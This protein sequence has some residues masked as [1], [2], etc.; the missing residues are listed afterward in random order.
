MTTEVK[1]P[2]PRGKPRTEPGTVAEPGQITQTG[3]ITIPHRPIAVGASGLYVLQPLLNLPGPFAT[4]QGPDSMESGGFLPAIREELRLDVDGRYPQMAASG[5]LR[6]GIAGR[7]NWVAKLNSTAPN[8]FAGPIFHA[9]TTGGP[10]FPYNFV[11]ITVTTSLIPSTQR[12]TA[13]FSTP[14]GSQSIH[15]YRFSSPYFHPVELE[16]DSADGT[17][18]ITTFNTGTH[19]NRPATLPIENLAIE[20]IYQRAGF[21]VTKSGGDGTVPIAGAGSNHRWSNMEMH[22]AMQT[23]WSKFANIAQWSMWV[24]FASLH[25]MGT[26]LGGIM[27]DD[28]GPNHRQGTAI[29]EDAFISVAPPGDPQPAAWVQRMRFW[30]ACHEAGHGFNLAHSWQESLGTPWIPLADEPEGRTFMNYP[31]NVSGGTSAFF[32]NFEYR[33]SDQELLFMRHAPERFV[34]MGAANWFDN[35]GFQQ[36]RVSQEPDLRLQLRANRDTPLFEFMEPVVLELKLTNI[37]R[38]PQLLHEGLLGDLDSMT[39]IVKKDNQ[40]ART[41]RPYAHY[42]R[43]ETNTVLDAGKSFYDSLFIGAGRGQWHIS[44]PGYYTVQ[45]ALHLP[46]QD[47]VS[48]P[49][50]LRVAPPRGG[51]EQEYLAQDFFSDGVGR[52]LNFDGSSVLKQDIDTL[53]EVA[54]RLPD[55]RAAVH[56]RIAL[57]NSAGSAS[58]QLSIP[59]SHHR[60]TS[61]AAAGAKFVSTKPDVKDVK[62]A[63]HLW[64]SAIVTKQNL[65]AETLGHVDL[66]YY[67]D[68]YSAW[69]AGQGDSHDAANVQ[70]H[71]HKTLS[72]RGVLPQV[73]ESIAARKREYESKRA[74]T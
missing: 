57:A 54:D 62:Q 37:S 26:S 17:T 12:A 73:L 19:P 64:E 22:D 38:E 68:A 7:A 33:F 25:E 16:F 42:C 28:I 69:L 35:H 4:D 10:S 27:F 23:Y 8:T 59:E 34:E 13:I 43:R 52:V 60:P 36:A 18:A 3:E 65:S 29:F 63:R 24:F 58:L 5:V 50:R 9:W 21:N 1:P 53:Q 46:A 67:A 51:Y 20:T 2:I 45:L 49:F 44:E 31:Y 48:N 55:S 47:V 61:A 74:R 14:G 66:K 30:T 56:A 11:K 39:I 15:R 6:N 32:S 70:E 72:A 71:L 40:P 41:Y